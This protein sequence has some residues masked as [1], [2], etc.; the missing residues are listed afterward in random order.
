MSRLDRSII[1]RLAAAV[2]L[3][4]LVGVVG[5]SGT[6]F[7]TRNVGWDDIDM[8]NFDRLRGSSCCSSEVDGDMDVLWGMNGTTVG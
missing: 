2:S 8:A 1:L 6:P 5:P 7:D 4:G 3:A